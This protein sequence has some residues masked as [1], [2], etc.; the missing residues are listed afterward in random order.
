MNEDQFISHV[1][2]VYYAKTK[3]K[4]TSA[5]TEDQELVI[6]TKALTKNQT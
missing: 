5:V 2:D 4:S 3:N 6:I 1:N